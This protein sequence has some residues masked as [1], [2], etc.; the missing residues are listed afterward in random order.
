MEIYPLKKLAA[1]FCF[2][3]MFGIDGHPRKQTVC[4]IFYG[5]SIL[6]PGL[7]KSELIQF[8]S[9]ETRP[10]INQSVTSACHS[11]MMYGTIKQS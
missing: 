2:I 11:V 5:A 6:G 10:A 9:S 1:F 3:W 4:Q 8:L 7:L